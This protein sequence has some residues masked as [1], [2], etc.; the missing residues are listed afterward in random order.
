MPKRARHKESPPPDF[1]LDRGLGRHVVAGALRGVG[2]TVYPMEDVFGDDPK[3]RRDDIW[4]GE[5][6]RRG[7]V[8]LMK[9]DKIRTKPR[10]RDALVRSGARA[11]CLTNAHLR[12]VV[13]AE[14]LVAQRGKIIRLSS[15]PGPF[16]YGVYPEGV[17]R[18][19]PPDPSRSK[20]R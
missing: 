13:M 19:F 9:D 14:L 5:V 18:L 12:G 2:L 6:T 17:K 4:I 15:K 20:P 8:I 1:F 3:W 10:E 7:W 16:V 11:F